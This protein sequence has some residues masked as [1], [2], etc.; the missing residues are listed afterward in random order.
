M[1]ISLFGKD[2]ISLKDG[3]RTYQDGPY[4][5]EQELVIS[6]SALNIDL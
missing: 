2:L 5:T 1:R 4:I 3:N 6:I